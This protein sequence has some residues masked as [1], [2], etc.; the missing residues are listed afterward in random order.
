MWLLIEALL[1]YSLNG[2]KMINE[3]T[4]NLE[5]LSNNVYFSTAV[6]VLFDGRGIWSDGFNNYNDKPYCTYCLFRYI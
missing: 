5:N 6:F 1:F 4:K 3:W 2:I